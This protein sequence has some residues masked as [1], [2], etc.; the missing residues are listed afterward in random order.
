MELLSRA[1]DERRL[2]KLRRNEEERVAEI[3]LAKTPLSAGSGPP[4]S[5][6]PSSE[7]LAA[8]YS[9]FKEE[10]ETKSSGSSLQA[11]QI[12]REPLT[13]VAIDGELSTA[14]FQG[15]EEADLSFFLNQKGGD[16]KVSQ[17]DTAYELLREHA[18]EQDTTLGKLSTYILGQIHKGRT[19]F[20]L[21]NAIKEMDFYG[22]KISDHIIRLKQEGVLTDYQGPKK[23]TIYQ[24]LAF[25]PDCPL[26]PVNHKY[27]LLMICSESDDMVV[28]QAGRHILSLISK[29]IS[30]FRST[31]LTEA[32]KISSFQVGGVIRWLKAAGIIELCGKEGSKIVY[33]I[34]LN[35]M[36]ISRNPDTSEQEVLREGHNDKNKPAP[37]SDSKIVREETDMPKVVSETFQEKD[38]DPEVLQ[39]IGTLRNSFSSKDR[40]LGE[41]LFSNLSK[42]KITYGDY[43]ERGEKSRYKVDMFLALQIGIVEKIDTYQCKILKRLTPGFPKLT[44]AQKRVASEIYDSFGE[45]KFSADMVLANL[46]YTDGTVSA[47]LHSFTLLKILDCQKDG[48]NQYQFRISPQEHPECFDVTA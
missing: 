27:N 26:P 15:T 5:T 3:E 48:V 37:I 14:A 38:Y 45:G 7:V 4:V 22:K 17:P 12:N 25:H 31:D 32:L 20:S 10:Q 8:P 33:Q 6:V 29:G 16:I 36:M 35:E 39:M 34:L 2:R 41:M 11:E 13:D 21:R 44:K 46:K 18:K 24:I 47:Y 30:S 9:A 1:V 43:V 42:G 28:S 40:R 19:L 23:G